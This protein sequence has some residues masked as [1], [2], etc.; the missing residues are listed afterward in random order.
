VLPG[1]AG[2]AELDMGGRYGGTAYRPG[3]FDGGYRAPGGFQSAPGTGRTVQTLEAVKDPMTGIFNIGPVLGTPS[4]L[5]TTLD[6]VRMRVLNEI[7]RGGFDWDRP[8]KDAII[9]RAANRAFPVFDLVQL[10]RAAAARA[11]AMKQPQDFEV[12]VRRSTEGYDQLCENTAFTCEVA[13]YHEVYD[14]NAGI[15][16]GLG[17]GWDTAPPLGVG[18]LAAYFAEVGTVTGEGEGCE[19]MKDMSFVRASWGMKQGNDIPYLDWVIFPQQEALPREVRQPPRERR[20]V[21]VREKE[22]MPDA[23]GRQRKVTLGSGGKLLALAGFQTEVLDAI[24]SVWDAI[25]KR[26]C[27]SGEGPG[28]GSGFPSISWP[29]F[30]NFKGKGLPQLD[31]GNGNVSDCT[32]KKI[33]YAQPLAEVPKR[34]WKDENGKWH[35]SPARDSQG[36]KI[37]YPRPQAMLA[38]IFNHFSQI[39]VNSMLENLANNAIEDAFYGFVNRKTSQRFGKASGRA[40]GPSFG[41]AM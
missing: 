36:R 24:Q 41:P 25:P 33:K 14:D 31:F 37:A 6:S 30:V 3:A 17:S 7:R 5:P 39:R 22:R 35:T 21:K 19:L 23:Y 15:P 10:Y 13:N 34:R 1:G 9:G 16:C 26:E 12:G 38:D 8:F 32:G 18:Q 4:T 27:G 11:Q 28:T 20:P 2:L 40:V 29:D